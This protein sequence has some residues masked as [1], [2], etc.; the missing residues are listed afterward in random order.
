VLI[1]YALASAALLSAERADYPELHTILDTGACL[2]SAVLAWQLWDTGARVR[3][4]F[5]VWLG[6]SLAVTSLLELLHV[7]VT[8]E[9]SGHLAFIV[10]A[11]TV[12]RPTTWPLAAHVLPIGIAGSLWLKY[13]EGRW[14]SAFVLVLMVLSGALFALFIWLPRYTA[15]AVVGITRHNRHRLLTD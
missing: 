6:I 12:L 3:R 14:T 8:V 7:L 2:L 1:A 5:L 11:R 15:P 10:H 13:R 4:P 9:W